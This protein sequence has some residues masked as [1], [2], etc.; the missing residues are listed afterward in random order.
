MPD[1]INREVRDLYERRRIA[2]EAAVQEREAAIRRGL[3]QKRKDIL[4]LKYWP[5]CGTERCVR[6][7]L[8]MDT[9][10]VCDQCGTGRK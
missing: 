2:K 9:S 1:E 10:V 5:P 6:A 4:A 3:E 7:V 8:A